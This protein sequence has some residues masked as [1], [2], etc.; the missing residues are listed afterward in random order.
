MSIPT[1]YCRKCKKFKDIT[2]VV[3]IGATCIK[4]VDCKQKV[5]L[6]VDLIEKMLGE[7]EKDVN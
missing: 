1:Y 5:E 6:S 3:P 4:C 2:E 7:F